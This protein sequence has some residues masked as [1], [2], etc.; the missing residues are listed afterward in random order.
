MDRHYLCKLSLGT[1][2]I[3][4]LIPYGD[5]GFNSTE[6]SRLWAGNLTRGG[7]SN[8]MKV[9]V[10]LCGSKTLLPQSLPVFNSPWEINKRDLVQSFCHEEKMAA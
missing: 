3:Y 5:I 9:E 7:N 6:E 2:V 8:I 10:L 1:R 4:F